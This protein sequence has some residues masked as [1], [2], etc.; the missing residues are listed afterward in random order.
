M[1]LYARVGRRRHSAMAHMVSL[2]EVTTLVNLG[3]TGEARQRLE[4]LRGHLPDG[5]YLRLQFWVAE[6]YVCFAEGE[7]RFDADQLHERARTALGITGAASLLGLCAWAHYTSGDHDQAWHLL[8]E[9]L[10]R[11]PGQL[12]DRL[13]P[14]LH[15]WMEA[16]LAES[17]W[18][19][20]APDDE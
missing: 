12:I 11:R 13:L 10:D 18:Q 3:R 19:P 5:N 8:S 20:P 4:Q 14:K 2:A 6:L 9:A 1:T 16:H 17:G 15:A 7:H